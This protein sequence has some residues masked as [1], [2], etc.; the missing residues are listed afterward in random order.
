LTRT[1]THTH[2]HTQVLEDPAT[3]L[4]RIDF[5][6]SNVLIPECTHGVTYDALYCDVAL[7][8]EDL[9]MLLSLLK[10]NGRM[11]V[12]IQEASRCGRGNNYHVSK[13]RSEKRDK[14]RKFILA[15][16]E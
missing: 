16:K 9:P 5:S 14:G 15:K 7:G 3:V 11:V 6:L 10:P 4:G 2:I 1:R 8:E 12:I 13:K